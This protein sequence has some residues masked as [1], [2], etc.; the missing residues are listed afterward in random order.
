MTYRLMRSARVIAPSAAFLA[1][2][3]APSSAQTIVGGSSWLSPADAAQLA[4]WLGQGPVIFTKIFQHVSNDGKTARDFH[5]AA[6]GR[7]PT[8]SVLST[9]PDNDLLNWHV[10]GGYN[11][12]SWNASDEF[13][14]TPDLADRTAFIFDL[15]TGL[16]LD[17]NDTENGQYQTFN[18]PDY[19]PFFGGIDL[20]VDFSLN[21]GYIDQSSYGTGANLVGGDFN[22]IN[23]RG[24]EVF[25]IS[26][27][28]SAEV[29]EP[30]A[31]ALLAGTGALG[32]LMVLRRRKR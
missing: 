29:P 3:A 15:T 4:T 20:Y 25:T 7:G 21:G 22:Y 5:A 24:L 16:R 28:T 8:I 18:Y 26:V 13:T 11:P 12:Q 9:K 30:G 6:N 27:D 14:L 10:I 2:L 19:G 31:W 23:S 32:G 1:L 17:Q